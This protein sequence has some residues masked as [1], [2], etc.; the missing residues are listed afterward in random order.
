MSKKYL[1]A[2]GV[3]HLWQKIAD[4]AQAKLVSGTNIKTVNGNSLLGSGNITI[5]GGGSSEE[6]VNLELDFSTGDIT[7]TDTT[8]TTEQA[9]YNAAAAAWT[10]E[11]DLYLVVDIPLGYQTV[12]MQLSDKQIKTDGTYYYFE[13]AF[14]P[15]NISAYVKY[16]GSSNY[17]IGFDMYE[18]LYKSIVKDYVK[19]QGTSNGWTYRK[20]NSGKLEQWKNISFITPEVGSWTSWNNMY[21]CYTDVTFG[22]AFAD[23]TY[24]IIQAC[25][26]QHYVSSSQPGGGIALNTSVARLNSSGC[27]AVLLR[28]AEVNAVFYISIYAVG[29][30]ST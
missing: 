8:Y 14:G 11:N 2:T 21:Y 30:Y 26:T 23:G 4:Y 24:P 22:K 28:P 5:G 13:S 15:T 9:I 17:T 7:I 3:T 18:L 10:A 29:T 6:R 25:T 1:D 27:R 12:Q 20:W 19:E 16:D